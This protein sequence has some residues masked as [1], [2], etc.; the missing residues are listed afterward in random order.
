MP[1]GLA[2]S[3]SP[4]PNP[5]F[6]ARPP[7]CPAL[8][9]RMGHV[10]V[11][12]HVESQCRRRNETRARRTET[13]L[14]SEK[15]DEALG[16]VAVGPKASLDGSGGPHRSALLWLKEWDMCVFKGTSKANAAAEMKRDRRN[17]ACEGGPL[18]S[19]SNERRYGGTSHAQHLQCR[20]ASLRRSR[21]RRKP[22]PP[23]K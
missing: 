19:Q 6:A 17:K 23:P 15:V 11:Q 8:V 2:A 21:A 18:V 20:S 7:L 1:F 4:A 12:G 13:H 16:A 3:R 22:M 14:V 10:R 9:E 5:P